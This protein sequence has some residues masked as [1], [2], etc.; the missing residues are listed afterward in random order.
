[1][2]E[3]THLAKSQKSSHENKVAHAM[4]VHLADLYH[5]YFKTHV[6]HW[7]I[8]GPMFNTLHA[9]FQEQYTEQWQALDEV[10]ERIRALDVLAPSTHSEFA[11]LSS[12]EKDVSPTYST[13]QEVVNHILQIQ[14]STA[15][16]AKDAIKVA[17]ENDDP[18]SADLMTAR[19]Q[20]HEKSIWML[21]SLLK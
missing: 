17:E 1:M 15:K 18:A 11:N 3:V 14:I 12:I 20:I 16:S 8:T 10:A 13:W 19:L 4:S 5:L 9:M 6:A 2:S 7:N 21:S